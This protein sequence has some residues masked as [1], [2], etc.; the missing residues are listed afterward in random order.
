M[1]IKQ[2]L[3]SNK[4]RLGSLGLIG[5]LALL[6]L[7]LSGP[8]VSAQLP[9]VCQSGE[10][11][12]P[13]CDFSGGKGNWQV[14]TEDG[15]ASF[16]ILQ[17]GGECH[18]PLCPAGYIVTEGHFVGGIYQ[19]VPVT[20]GNTYYANIIWLVFD[21]LSNDAGVNGTVGGI[22][23]RIGID[24][25][26][27]TDSRSPN[28]VWSE[29][30][31]RND[32]KICGVEYVTATAQADVITVFLRLDDT[33]RVRAAEKGY[34]IPPSKDK[35]WIDDIGLKQIDGSAAP[36]PQPTE[37]PPAPTDTPVPPPPTE[38]PA[39]TDEPPAVETEEL[40]AAP[41]E[42][43]VAAVTVQE[44][45]S[46]EALISDGDQAALVD[47]PETVT[48][49]LLVEPTIE[50][51]VVEATV[52]PPPTLTPTHT[53]PPTET[54]V[55]RLAPEATPVAPR[56][57][58]VDAEP[59]PA[60][61]GLSLETMGW[62]GTAACVGGTFMVI[63][64]IVFAGLAWLYRLGWGDASRDDLSADDEDDYLDDVDVEIVE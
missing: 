47:Q 20:A 49:T 44:D 37:P 39:E 42:N 27:G 50:L 2:I 4:K 15:G 24:P 23:R 9:D 30:N 22:G 11:I 10:N 26:G 43:Q 28:V 56:P 33:W 64:V 51:L 40:E 55:A 6:W 61:S 19:Q 35:F 32:C 41:A 38:A 63:M 17:G 59:E 12:L 48:E 7:G 36:A 60:T 57:L 5:L 46:V 16:D 54:A 31:W 1:R 29:D 62:V 34:A 14:F 53:P 3:W 13:N 45:E 52:P 18:A 58:A 21:S 8:A 25:T